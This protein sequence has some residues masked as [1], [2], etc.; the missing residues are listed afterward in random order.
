VGKKVIAGHF[1][2]AV[3]KQ[4]RKLALEQ[5]S[6]VQTLLIEAINELFVKYRRPPIA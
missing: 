6:T 1:D 4:L 3:S 2:P 5:D